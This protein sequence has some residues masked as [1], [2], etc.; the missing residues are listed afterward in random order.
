MKIRWTEKKSNMKV[1]NMID[2]PKKIIK[3]MEIRKTKFLGHVMRYNTFI[4]NIMEAK[5]NGKKG[6]L[7]ET[8]LGNM[9]NLL[10][11]E[12]DKEMK[13]LSDKREHWLQRQD[14]AFRQ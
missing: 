14:E 5:I 6:R 3:I 8:N 11:L 13:R 2:K 9:K 10:S 4:I 1:L 7:K 12:S